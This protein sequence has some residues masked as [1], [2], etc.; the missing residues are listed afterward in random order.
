MTF[1]QYMRNNNIGQTK[2]KYNNSRCVYTDH[3]DGAE[4]GRVVRIDG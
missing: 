4:K 3:S 2:K 1:Y